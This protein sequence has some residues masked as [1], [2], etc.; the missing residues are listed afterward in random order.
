MDD[1]YN[2]T[3]PTMISNWR[4]TWSR[5]TNNSTSSSFPFGFVQLNGNGVTQAFNNPA[6]APGGDFS[7]AYGFAGLRWYGLRLNPNPNP[8]LARP[9]IKPELLNPVKYHATPRARTSC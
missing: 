4:S 9:A 3:F 6:E 8:S 7:P 1:G 5:L 2:C